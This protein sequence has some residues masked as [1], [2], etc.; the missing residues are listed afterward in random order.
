MVLFALELVYWPRLLLLYTYLKEHLS[1]RPWHDTPTLSPT[2]I[3][4]KEVWAGNEKPAL[5]KSCVGW[6]RPCQM[7]NSSSR[8]NFNWF[9]IT[10]LF[11]SLIFETN[12]NCSYILL[13]DIVSIITQWASANIL[14][15]KRYTNIFNKSASADRKLIFIFSG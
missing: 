5:R 4:K 12:L 1:C 3:K 2:Q 9:N 14:Y 10:W 13:F 8:I 11:K 15:Q 7:L 6:Y